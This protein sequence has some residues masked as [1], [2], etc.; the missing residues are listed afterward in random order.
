LLKRFIQD[1]LEKLPTV[2]DL[3]TLETALLNALEAAGAAELA[4][5]K[6]MGSKLLQALIGVVAAT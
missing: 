5:A 1:V 2:T 6:A 3:A 4:V